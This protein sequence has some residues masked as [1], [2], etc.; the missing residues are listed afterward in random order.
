M[1][2]ASYRVM[3]ACTPIS[4]G[5]LGARQCVVASG[6]PWE[7]SKREI[8]EAV[9]MKAM[10]TQETAGIRNMDVSQG[11]LGAVTRAS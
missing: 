10:E 11:K 5:G 1:K 2:N 4:K 3:E 7:V 6:A 9:K 8:G